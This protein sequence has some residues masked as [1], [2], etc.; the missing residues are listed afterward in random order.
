MKVSAVPFRELG[1]SHLAR[2]REILAAS[3]ALDSPYFTPD[4]VAAVADVR[5]TVEVGVLE[6]GGQVVGFFPYERSDGN[7]ADPVALDFSDFQA[8]L[9]APGTAWDPAEILRGCRLTAFRF[10]HL[11]AEQAPFLPHHFS[12]APSPWVDL[13]RGVA[14]WRAERKQAGSSEI[15][16]ILYKRRKAERRA[17][18]IRFVLQADPEAVFPELLRWKGAQLVATGMP[19]R[20]E[21]PWVR[22]LLERVRN[23][24][25]AAFSG[26]LS[27]LYLGDRLAAAHFGMRTGT[28]LH[29]WFPAYDAELSAHTPGNICLLELADAVAADGVRRIDLG[30][31]PERYKQALA[32]GSTPVAEGAVHL[33]AA[34][35]A[36]SRARHQA[37]EWVR[38]S[39][40]RQVLRGPWRWLRRMASRS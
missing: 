12:V 29:Y 28:V 17:G 16:T 34:A 9:A 37:V 7:V 27:A 32:S 35:G 18:P 14:A 39:P 22:Q 3:P 11:L 8:V 13:S 40:L 1:P 4:F 25:T 38:H 23:Q 36:L 33:R 2:W 19:N 31:G 26:V 5:P 24:Q 21:R 10:D 30:K 20:L 6:E 15:E